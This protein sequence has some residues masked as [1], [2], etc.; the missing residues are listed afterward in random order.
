MIKMIDFN[1]S[2]VF[3]QILV[4]F[5]ILLVLYLMTLFIL[6]TD[7]L[8]VYPTFI[9]KQKEQTTIVGEQLNSAQLAKMNFNT[10]FPFHKNYK[11]IAQS[12]GGRTGRQFSYQYWM[13]VNSTDQNDFKDLVIL[14]KGDT[15]KY[16]ISYYDPNTLKKI[17][18]L[19]E[20][21]DYM[22]KCPLIKFT[23]GYKNLQVEL[24]TAKHPNVVIPIK[25]DGLNEDSKRRNLLSL[26]PTD[27]FMFTFVF[28]ENYSVMDGTEN[29]IRFTF[30]INDLPLQ[31]TTGS[32]NPMLFNNALV[33]NDG[34]LTILPNF[35]ENKNILSI[36]NLKHFN[37]AKSESDV[38]SDFVKMSS[39]FGGAVSNNQ[40][41]YTSV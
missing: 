37:Y 2:W 14:L 40:Y 28:E 9:V 12:V 29:G 19:T 27:W 39:K 41:I 16:G 5:V 15:N 3:T 30:Y 35:L 25:L 24:N 8:V 31:T 10:I 1:V 18:S 26:L 6:Q 20:K 22:I 32:T 34:E 21:P 7:A 23:D 11:K 38:R 33:T 13:K 4:A 17:N 36:A